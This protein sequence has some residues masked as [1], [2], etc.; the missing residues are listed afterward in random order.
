MLSIIQRYTLLLLKLP[1]KQLQYTKQK[2]GTRIITLVCVTSAAVS[3]V[4]TKTC[5]VTSRKVL[6]YN[7]PLP[8]IHFTDNLPNTSITRNY[9]PSSNIRNSSF[10]AKCHW[11][12]MILKVSLIWHYRLL[13]TGGADVKW[14]A[15]KLATAAGVA[16]A[17]KVPAAAHVA[18]RTRRNPG[19][20]PDHNHEYI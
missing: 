12:C 1:A 2:T 13:A 14:K 3:D 17:M 10:T 20:Y 7:I 18:G 4:C 8:M 6:L 9:T 11:F 5:R 15:S 16:A 19:T